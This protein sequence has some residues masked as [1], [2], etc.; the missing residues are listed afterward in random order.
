MPN[1]LK[2]G[3][4]AFSAAGTLNTYPRPQSPASLRISEPLPMFLSHWTRCG[5]GR[6]AP[7][8]I[9]AARTN[10]LAANSEPQ[11]FGVFRAFGVF[12]VLGVLGANSPR[13]VC[14]YDGA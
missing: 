14:A 3:L 10:F 5:P 8:K 6:S 9:V 11:F 7:R 12:G 13:A 2:P 1:R 4:H